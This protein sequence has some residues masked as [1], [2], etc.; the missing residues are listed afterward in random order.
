MNKGV[1]AEADILAHKIGQLV[2]A[3]GSVKVDPQRIRQELSPQVANFEVI[4]Y[5][6]CKQY[7]NGVLDRDDYRKFLTDIAPT[8]KVISPG[9]ISQTSGDHGTNTINY[10]RD[11][12]NTR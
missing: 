11:V 4:D 9:G 8:L 12:I 2:K 1:Q 3:S 5:R 7:A 6:M 10:G